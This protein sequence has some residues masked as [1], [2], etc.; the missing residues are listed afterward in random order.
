MIIIFKN[1]DGGVEITLHERSR[2]EDTI[3]FFC[4]IQHNPFTVDMNVELTYQ[5]ID[6]F[7]SGI[8]KMYSIQTN[9]LFLSSYDRDLV[10]SMMLDSSGHIISSVTVYAG[11]RG[12]L[13]FD[14][15][16]DQS[17]LGEIIIDN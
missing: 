3:S 5:E 12:T 2:N 14:F 9:K 6:Y 17:F 10:I 11:I 4:L 15:E 13:K 8:Q 16:F 1:Q 7:K